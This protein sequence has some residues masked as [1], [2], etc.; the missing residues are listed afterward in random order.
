VLQV[1]VVVGVDQAQAH[2]QPM[3]S[4]VV[5]VEVLVPMEVPLELEYLVKETMVGLNM[6]SQPLVP[7]LVNITA[8]EAEGRVPLVTTL[9][10]AALACVQAL[11]AVGYFMLAA[12]AA[13]FMKHQQQEFMV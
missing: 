12:V 9:V 7:S 6:L 5:L 1:V 10:V 3:V 2:R 8:A 13:V 11:Q 4:L